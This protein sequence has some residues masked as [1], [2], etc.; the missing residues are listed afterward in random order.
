MAYKTLLLVQTKSC[1]P[2]A[3]LDAAIGLA[4]GID[5]HLEVLCLGIDRSQFDMV[6]FAG[7]V[8]VAL[9]SLIEDAQ[10][11]ASDLLAK[12]RERLDPEDIRWS[13][14]GDIVPPGMISGAVARR[15]RYADLL[16][17]ALPRGKGSS[18]EAEA[19]VEAALFAARIPVLIVPDGAEATVQNRQVII[20]WNDGEEALSAVR[21][22][23]PVLQSAKSVNIVVVDPPANG[24]E[25]SDPGGALAQ[26]LS[27]HGV[28]TDISVLARGPD[29]LAAM[30][31]RHAAE[32]GANMIVMGAYGHSRLMET[33]LGGV[34]RDMLKI[35]SIP[36]LMAR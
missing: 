13:V 28:H 22:A 35:A 26:M 32:S 11:E 18:A 17:A 34:T 23:M 24:A 19:I 33:L 6:G 4:R 9:P 36:A 15:A 12:M 1:E 16:L 2:K 31:C 30:L 8:P 27:R 3:P 10:N 21:A 7:A 25:R 29:T 14:D 20:A 5:A